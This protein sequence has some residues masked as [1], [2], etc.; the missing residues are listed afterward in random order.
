LKKI[1]LFA[2]ALIST[3]ALASFSLACSRA[4]EK[5]EQM[6]PE[7]RGMTLEWGV[8]NPETT[9][10]VGTINVYNPNPIS[11]QVKKIAYA[12]NMDG[13]NVGSAES[14]GLQIEKNAEFP[15]KVS[16]KINNA[17]IPG[18]WTEHIKRTEN[19]EV[20]V[21]ISPT[22]DLKITDF[23]FPFKV[24]QSIQTNLLSSL[25][26]V[27]PIPLE[28]KIKLPIVGEKSIFKASI[29]SLTGKWGTITPQTTQINLLA[30]IHNENPYPL[31]VPKM[32]Y[33]M[34][35]NGITLGSGESRLQFVCAPNSRG[36]VNLVA[37]LNTNQMDK[38]FVS[39]VRQGEKSIFNMSVSLVFDIPGYDKYSIPIWEGSQNMETD[40]LG[41]VK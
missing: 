23:T 1:V 8:V 11:L 6:K 40:I 10:I 13:I 36:D 17:K 9:E 24:K 15:I 18:F 19:S 29:E 3:V 37:T 4:Q 34:D 27:G 31:V 12:I 39:H 38:W 20:T 28:K 35:I 16:A 26:K 22:F 32:E 21:E 2:F 41:K 5:I 30:I 7:M 33:N 14:P 25:G